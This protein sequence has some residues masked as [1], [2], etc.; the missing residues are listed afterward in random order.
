LTVILSCQLCGEAVV[1]GAGVPM[2][3][4]VLRDFCDPRSVPALCGGNGTGGAL[5]TTSNGLLAHLSLL[6]VSGGV[7]IIRRLDVFATY[8]QQPLL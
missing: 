8:G 1:R 7:G 5:E 4:P 3:G 2:P 6:F